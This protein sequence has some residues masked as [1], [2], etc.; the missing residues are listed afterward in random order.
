MFRAGMRAAPAAAVVIAAAVVAVGISFGGSGPAHGRGPLAAAMSSLPQSTTVAGFTDWAYVSR[1]GSLDTARE[2]DL[3][4]R[5]A[6]IDV[7][8]GLASALGLRLRDLQWEVYG[9]GGYG[10][11]V[12]VRLKRAMPTA[13]RLHKAGYRQDKSTLVWLATGRLAAEEPIYGSVAVL[14][15]DDT[16]V[17]GVGPRAVRAV[18]SVVRGNASPFVRNRAVA[19]ATLALPNVHTALIQTRGLGCAATKPGRE[20]ETARQVEAAEQRFGRVERYSV[21]ARGLRDTR[22]ETQRFSVVMT[23]PSAA[24]AAEQARVR[25]A[26]SVG[27]FIGRRGDMAEVLRFRSARSDGRTALLTYDHPADSEYLMTGQGPLLPASC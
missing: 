18:A 20:R 16:L 8:P 2:L 26:L 12:V 11:A 9:Q 4:T 15:R 6:L 17:L 24:T 7:A 14:R 3:V 25:G 5:S 27:P 1:R 19:D 10:E 21:L 13:A 22:S 23:F